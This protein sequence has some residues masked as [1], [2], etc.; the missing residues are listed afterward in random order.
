M[1]GINEKWSLLRERIGDTASAVRNWFADRLGIRS[2]SR[3]FAKLGGH[4]MEG[5]QQGLERNEQGPLAE[6]DAFSRRIRQAGA[7]LMLGT[8]AFGAAAGEGHASSGIAF[9]T[10]PPL[11]AAATSGGLEIHGGINITVTAAPGMDEQALS[12]LVATEVQR[13]LQEAEQNM[14]AR[15]RSAFY[16]TD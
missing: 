16:D 10:R 9:D 15:Q 1:N 3:V 7:G 4:T 6:I 11:S 5:Y 13:A 2:P 12:R 14:R 8:A